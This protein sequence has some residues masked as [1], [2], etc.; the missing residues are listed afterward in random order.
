MSR[1]FLLLVL[2][3]TALAGERVARLVPPPIVINGLERALLVQRTGDLADELTVQLARALREA[4]S[5]ASENGAVLERGV[6]WQGLDHVTAV[7]YDEPSSSEVAG[8]AGQHA[9]QAVLVVDARSEQTNRE[10]WEEQRSWVEMV[11]GQAVQRTGTVQCARR[12]I[13][14]Q[15]AVNV[16][17]GA[18]GADLRRHQE[19]FTLSHADCQE[20]NERSIELQTNEQIAAPA[21]E[22]VAGRVA[23]LITPQLDRVNL[24][25][26][27]DQATRPSL[28]LA[29]DG[30]WSGFLGASL[31]ALTDDPYAPAPIYHAG[32]ALEAFGFVSEA[33]DLYE[34]AIRIRNDGTFRDGRA[35]ATERG[36]QLAVLQRAYGITRGGAVPASVGPLLETARKAATTPVRGRPA[37]VRGGRNRRPLVFDEPDGQDVGALA[38]GTAVRVIESRGGFVLVQLPDGNE[39]WMLERDL[40]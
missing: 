40:M 19:P 34:Y 22:L 7:A 14:M 11:D 23:K 6:S 3:S 10:A 32:L 31:E 39:G 26:V 33:H 2:P 9:A 4:A 29:R 16:F 38:G 8:L 24:S 1:W 15:V 12:T 27:A 20:R 37:S 35:R 17:D 28:R 25:L 36:E 21:L 5:P 30:D 13:S 18:T